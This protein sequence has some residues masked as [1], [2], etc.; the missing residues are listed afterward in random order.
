MLDDTILCGLPTRKLAAIL[1]FFGAD[2]SIIMNPK[3]GEKTIINSVFI[4]L[5]GLCMKEFR[6][7]LMS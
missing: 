4:A 1:K 5:D 7:R 3:N 2:C 6:K